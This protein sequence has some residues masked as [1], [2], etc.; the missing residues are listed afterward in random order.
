M[1]QP[2]STMGNGKPDMQSIPQLLGRHVAECSVT[3]L[4]SAVLSYLAS[5]PLTKTIELSLI[6]L[7]WHP[8]DKRPEKRRDCTSA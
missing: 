1:A 3:V 7:N 6:L 8:D 2:F 4:Y 5:L